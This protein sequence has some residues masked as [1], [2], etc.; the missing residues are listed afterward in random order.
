MSGGK[1]LLRY[2]ILGLIMFAELI[3]FFSISFLFSGVSIFRVARYY[4]CFALGK[5]LFLAFI[6]CGLGAIFTSIYHGIFN[7]LP[8]GLNYT[9]LL[10]DCYRKGT[11]NF[12]WRDTNEKVDFGNNR[13]SNQGSLR[14]IAAFFLAN[15][16]KSQ[17]FAAAEEKINRLASA[18]HIAGGN[19]I[20]SVAAF[21]F[22]TFL[23]VYKFSSIEGFFSWFVIFNIVIVAHYISYRS[24]VEN[25]QSI[26]SQTVTAEMSVRNDICR[27]IYVTDLEISS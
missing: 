25:C 21:L 9:S 20:A 12:F 18:A 26:V 22:W 2:F 7:L 19:F 24:I 27:N 3:L 11:F 14:V 10:R 4:P 16:N 1:K 15:K 23:Y 8:V 5:I 17:V 13:I 6:C